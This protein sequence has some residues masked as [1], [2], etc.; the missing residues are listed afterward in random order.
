MALFRR[1]QCAPYEIAETFLGLAPVLFLAAMRTRHDEDLA[2]IG[3]SLAREYPEACLHVVAQR[4]RAI[5]CESQ[6]HRR[7]HLVHVLAAGARGTDECDLEIGIGDFESWPDR[8]THACY[9]RSWR[10]SCD[11]SGS[12]AITRTSCCCTGMVMPCFLNRRQ[13][14]LFTSERTLLTPFMGSRI[15]KRTST[16]MP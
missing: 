5:Q 11:R 16:R 10:R 7:C 3:D 8:Q 9:L 6:L 1:H 13:I 12:C 15:Q 2:G 14:S 4:G